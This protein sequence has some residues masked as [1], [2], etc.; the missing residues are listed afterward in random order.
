MQV[1]QTMK[2]NKMKHN[3]PKQNKEQ[4]IKANQNTQEKKKTPKVHKTEYILTQRT[5]THTHTHTKIIL[6][7]KYRT[8]YNDQGTN[9]DSI[10]KDDGL[11]HNR[12]IV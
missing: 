2:Q 7:Q 6:P 3:I 1:K 11:K 9:P 12:R 4:Q 8:A 10:E 5:Q